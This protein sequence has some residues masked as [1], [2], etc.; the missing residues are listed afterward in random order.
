MYNIYY[1]QHNYG[2]GIDDVTITN[3]SVHTRKHVGMY[4]YNTALQ[5]HSGTAAYAVPALQL[6]LQFR[7]AITRAAIR[8]LYARGVHVNTMCMRSML[9]VINKVG[10]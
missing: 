4:D 10:I 6:V 9:H 5:C 2:L 7:T 3:A 1:T 8:T